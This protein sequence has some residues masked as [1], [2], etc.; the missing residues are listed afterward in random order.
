MRVGTDRVVAGV[1]HSS[2]EH[3]LDRL[4]SLLVNIE[5][6]DSMLSG[7]AELAARV[8]HDSSCG[9]TVRFGGQMLTVGSSDTRAEALD[10][11]QYQAGDGP[12]LEALK[13]SRIVEVIDMGRENRWPDYR[14]SVANTGLRC[15][16]SL[17]L[18]ND[19]V[20]FGAINAYGFERPAMFGEAE[21]RELEL[22]AARAV[23][24]LQ[25]A[26]RLT[27]DTEL[28][29]QMDEALSSRT[30]IDQALGIIMGQQRCTPRAAFEL[31]RR[32]SQNNRRRLR[33][34]ATELVERTTGEP[35]DLGRGFDT[36]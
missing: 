25:L 17:P 19:G 10:E 23:G 16:L 28:L 30:V 29:A 22:Y 14:A 21:R 13:T 36:D 8:V 12:C 11:S 34:V 31:L 6:L 33:D 27:R 4:Q 32:E 26:R 3:P 9:I 2:D 24:T 5:S 15:S 35:P 7:L 20:T 1:P 18:V